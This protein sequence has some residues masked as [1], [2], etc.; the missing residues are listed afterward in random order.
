MVHRSTFRRNATKA[1]R[2]QLALALSMTLEQ[3]SIRVQDWFHVHRSAGLILPDKWFGRPRDNSHE[4]DWAA[5]TE[6]SLLVSLDGG[7]LLLTFRGKVAVDDQGMQLIIRDFESFMFRQ[8]EYG[9][10]SKV[11]HFNYSAGVVVLEDFTTPIISAMEAESPW[12][13]R[14]EKLAHAIDRV[15]GMC[16]SQP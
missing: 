11:H 9:S 14:L 6:D 10:D 3:G 13:T 12:T 8:I 2:E 5:A 7:K 1:G 4:L 16:R 15:I